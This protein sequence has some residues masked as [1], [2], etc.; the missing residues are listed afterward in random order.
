MHS[1][2]ILPAACSNVEEYQIDSCATTS[3]LLYIA[4]EITLANPHAEPDA[5]PIC[6]ED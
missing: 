1:P 4:G 2:R 3:F 6:L 5:T